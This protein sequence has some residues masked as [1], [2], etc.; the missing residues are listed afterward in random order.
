MVVV[1]SEFKSIC[2]EVPL[3][4]GKPFISCPLGI[5]I[6]WLYSNT[7]TVPGRIL[8]FKSSSRAGTFTA[9]VKPSEDNFNLLT[10]RPNYVTAAITETRIP[11]Q[12]PFFDEKE[13]NDAEVKMPGL[14][15]FLETQPQTPAETIA[16]ISEKL[17]YV[18][19]NV[20]AY[21]TLSNQSKMVSSLEK[22]L[23]GAKKSN[24]ESM[25]ELLTKKILF[26]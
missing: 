25:I 22:S 7:F 5:H 19:E 10:Q 16:K 2:E 18:Y 4:N 23:A 20:A 13:L 9:N 6:P 3:I 1:P 24:N 26:L 11:G 15:T 8:L 14:K 17:A 12:A 21:K